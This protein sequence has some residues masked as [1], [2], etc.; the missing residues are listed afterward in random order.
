MAG[1]RRR[2]RMNINFCRAVLLLVQSSCDS[3]RF[4][5]IVPF[6]SDCLL[7]ILFVVRSLSLISPSLLFTSFCLFEF[8]S[9]IEWVVI[10]KNHRIIF[11]QGDQYLGLKQKREE[12]H[13]KRNGWVLEQKQKIIVPV[14]EYFS[15]LFAEK[16]G[17]KH[18]LC[19]WLQRKDFSN[20]WDWRGREEGKFEEREKWETGKCL[21]QKKRDSLKRACVQ[22][23]MF[24]P[25]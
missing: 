5:L 13:T 16:M 20:W 15:F 6:D 3:L 18:L 1:W 8:Y 17:L 2:Q 4:S 24:V 10:V 9:R 12:L 22:S 7:L 23:C 21:N 11:C 14:L 25:S 19:R